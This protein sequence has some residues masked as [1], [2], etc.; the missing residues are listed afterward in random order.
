[1]DVMIVFEEGILLARE[2]VTCTTLWSE[3]PHK[4]SCQL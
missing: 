2:E 4:V 3:F 1:M